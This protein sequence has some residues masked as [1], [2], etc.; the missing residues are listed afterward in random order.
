MELLEFF[1]VISPA[2][3]LSLLLA[4]LSV[5]L[6]VMVFVPLGYYLDFKGR[7]YREKW[8]EA[9]NE[10]REEH[11]EQFN[12]FSYRISDFLRFGKK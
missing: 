1:D 8:F 6:I 2:E 3:F 7:Y 10:R 12:S 11:P 4:A 5:P 9:E